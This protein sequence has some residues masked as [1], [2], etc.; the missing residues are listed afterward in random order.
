[1]VISIC[2]N[3]NMLDNFSLFL[4]IDPFDGVLEDVKI[5]GDS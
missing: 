5:M 2:P 4:L 1:M 3:T